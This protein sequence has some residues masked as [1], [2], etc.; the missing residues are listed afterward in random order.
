MNSTAIRAVLFDFD[1]TLTAPGTIDFAAIKHD[2]GCPLDQAILEFVYALPEAEREAAF[3][4][5]DEHEI[6]AA[7]RSVPNDGSEELISFL[8][9]R[10]VPLAVLSR[11]SLPAILRAL[12]N[13]PNTSPDDFQVIV[14]RDG[15][16]HK[17]DPDGVLKA[18][19]QMGVPVE[20]LLVVGDYVF[21]ID[22]AHNAGSPS[23]L[24]TNGEPPLYL[25]RPATYTISRLAELLPLVDERLPLAVGKLPNRF[26]RRALADNTLDDPC[27]LVAPGLGEDTAVVNLLA[28]DK[29]DSELLVLKSDP[30][31]FSAETLGYSAVIVN[32]ND[33]ATAGAIPRWL[34]TTLLFPPGTT[35]RQV[36]DVMRD[37]QGTARRFE[38]TLCGGHTEVTDSVTRPIV[39]GQ[40]IGTVAQER[41]IDKRHIDTGDHI[42]V[43][44]RL[45]VEGTAILATDCASSL[46]RLGMDPAAL[47]KS[48]EF[49]EV[50]GISILPEAAVAAQVV[51]VTGMHDVTEGGFA[52]A[53][54][55]LSVAS[56]HR[57]R[58]ALDRV[59]LYPETCRVCDLA[60]VD[61]FGLIGSGT[62]LIA[63]RPDTSEEL[64]TRLQSASIEATCIGEFGE[65]GEGV[66]AYRGD[67]IA[68]DWPH[69]EVDELARAISQLQSFLETNS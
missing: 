17:P 38:V 23:V 21:D 26:L 69:F 37:L 68:A 36:L 31:T 43:T 7:A 40:V 8:H 50:P 14:A 30:I 32:S 63:C 12:E 6:D 35:A 33:I 18:A 52:T 67:G 60:G 58:V 56:G 27:L 47:S 4:R 24:L 45:A 1:G 48:Q 20:S 29:T 39:V 11:N 25:T 10:C 46:R 34:L 9:S 64:L 54:E 66:D 49:F 57:I 61:A 53:L 28:A 3:T 13:F 44:K 41:L 62:L 51:G 42:L 19:A 65:A 59:P 2:I 5:L 55:E 22:A 15:A 16:R